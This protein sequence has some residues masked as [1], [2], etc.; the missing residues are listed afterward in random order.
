MFFTFHIFKFNL[1]FLLLLLHHT[2]SFP[3]SFLSEDFLSKQQPPM[4][5][6][7]ISV[8]NL[9]LT[10]RSS[11][12]T[13]TKS[14]R[15]QLSLTSL[16]SPRSPQKSPK[17]S[18]KQS[19]RLSPTTTSSTS[20]FPSSPRKTY[21]PISRVFSNVLESVPQEEYDYE[22]TMIEWSEP[23]N[24]QIVKKIGRGKYSDVF[25][26]VV[27]GSHY[28]CC[29]KSLKP[30]REEKFRREIMVLQRLLGG[31][32]IV[33][34]Y[35]CVMEKSTGTPSLIM[36]YVNNTN[37]KE[38]YPAFKMRDIKQYIREILIG[39]NF[40]HSKGIIHRDIK[41]QNICYNN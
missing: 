19:P 40:T 9:K 16:L 31:P 36:E 14:P 29:I 20:S 4:S 15:F 35:D 26:G 34:L 3:Y 38:I 22:K 1:I 18:P 5:K 17:Q 37:Y 7:K 27:K 10:P 41:P 39:L 32:N 28:P 23:N 8:Q 12:Q 30:V 13:P 33:K 24:Y 6:P 2:E 21:P 25:L 11:Q